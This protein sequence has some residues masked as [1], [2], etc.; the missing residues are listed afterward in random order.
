MQADT[1]TR[2]YSLWTVNIYNDST[3]GA[4]FESCGNSFP[5][6]ADSDSFCAC[7]NDLYIST[8]YERKINDMSSVVGA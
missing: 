6:N 3:G 1:S 4:S 5:T 2:T 8:S 7:L